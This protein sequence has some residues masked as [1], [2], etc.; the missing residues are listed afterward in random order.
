MTQRKF[1]SSRRSFVAGAASAAALVAAPAIVRAQQTKRFIRPLV[2][3]LNA[4]AGDPTYESIAR[5]SKILKE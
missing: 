2:A 4:K 5:I 1:G 3:G